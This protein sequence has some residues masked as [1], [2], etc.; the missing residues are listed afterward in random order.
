MKEE[1]K[2]KL[3]CNLISSLFLKRNLASEIKLKLS[4]SGSKASRGGPLNV[5]NISLTI[6]PQEVGAK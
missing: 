6:L 1:K 4:M 2:V 3:L 5:A